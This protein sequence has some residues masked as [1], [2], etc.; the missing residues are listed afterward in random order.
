MPF[1]VAPSL[2]PSLPGGA[3]LAQARSSKIGNDES[4]AGE[5]RDEPGEPEKGASRIARGRSCPPDP[6]GAGLC[7]GGIRHGGRRCR[8]CQVALPSMSRGRPTTYRGAPRPRS[9]RGAA[10]ST[11]CRGGT[12][13]TRGHPEPRPSRCLAQHGLVA[14]RGRA[15]RASRNRGK[16]RRGDQALLGQQPGRARPRAKLHVRPRSRGRGRRQGSFARFGF[17]SSPPSP[18]CH[19]PPHG[20]RGG[21]SR[22]LR[23]A[24][25]A[26]TQ[27]RD[28]VSRTRHH[29]GRGR[30]PRRGR[31]RVSLRVT[32]RPGQQPMP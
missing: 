11:R 4:G 18:S 6:C 1:C 25:R 21:Q 10:E 28:R 12:L 2:N 15:S 17:G 23:Q 19:S 26:A 24:D 13:R 7:G 22:E 8:P 20:R 27:L 14:V 32:A 30:A 5:L 3:S 31:K 9:R 16:A 29:A